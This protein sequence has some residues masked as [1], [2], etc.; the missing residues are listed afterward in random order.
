MGEARRRKLAGQS[1]LSFDQLDA[2]LRGHGVNTAEFGFYDQPA[3]MALELYSSWVLTRPCDE[4]YEAHARATVPKLATLIETRLAAAG[5]LGAVKVATAMARMLDRL[6]VWSFA[7]RGSLTIEIPERPEVGRR[8]FPACEVCADPDDVTG[9]GWLVAPPFIVV[10]PTLRHQKWVD[11]QPAIAALLPAVV[12]A[13]AGEWCVPRWFDVVSDN[14]VAVHGLEPKDLTPRLP[15]LLNRDL[16]RVERSLPARE[17]RIGE[18][19]LR[20]IASSVTVSEHTLQQIPPL[21]QFSSGLLPMELWVQHV[22]PAFAAL[23][24]RDQNAKG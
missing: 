13:E 3:F 15:Y 17:V 19:S 18:L 4:A 8:Y 9:H 6:G 21:D 12:A 2:G 11:L 22:A 7:A 20:Y 1:S 14:V 23:N 5:T 24:G 16:A 10:D